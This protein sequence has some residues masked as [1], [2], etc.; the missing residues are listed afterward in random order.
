MSGLI[1]ILISLAIYLVPTWVAWRRH[2]QLGMVA[3]LNILL[4]WTI[5]GWAVALAIACGD[6]G[7][8]Q[9]AA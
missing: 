3:V 7:G 1:V 6:R 4:G 5:I 2:H 8:K 9:V